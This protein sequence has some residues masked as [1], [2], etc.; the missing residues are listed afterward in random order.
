MKKTIILFTCLGFILLSSWLQAQECITAECHADFKK[1]KLLHGPVAN[2]C[3][4]CHIQ[5]GE[6]E[7]TFEDKERH[8]I[9][10]HD[11]QRGGA[12]VHGPLDSG[13][14]QDCHDPHGGSD[15]SFLKAERM[16]TMCFECHDREPMNKKVVHGPMA[17]GNCAICHNPHSSDYPMLL[18][19][20][21][22]TLC[23]KCH[24]DKDYSGDNMFMH[25]PLENGCDGCH[26][27]HASDFSYQLLTPTENIC[28]ACHE[29][30][31]DKAGK[32]GFKH[33]IVLQEKK[34]ANCHDPHG[35]L[36]DH[37]LT[38][39]QLSVCLGCH[40]KPIIGTDGKDY[41]I[42]TI[43]SNNPEKH[44]PVSDGNC[45]GC[46]NPH[47]SNS[48]KIL[49]EDFPEDF[50]TVF[51]EEKYN[52]CFQCHENTLVRD[53][54]TTTLTNFR[55]GSQN[56]HYLHVNREKGR[57]CR[58]C[59]EVHAGDQPK[60]I[61]KETP[62]GEWDIPLGFVKS[63]TGGSCSPGCHKPFSYDRGK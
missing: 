32:V 55:N 60:H 17:T 39:D 25:T 61:R 43:V 12:N 18:K 59:H 19:G 40:N 47:G 33:P 53:Q 2:D 37:N 58:A 4:A 41:N 20:S 42:Y 56:L 46:H 24:T 35:S 45:T 34:C 57:T 6:H 16:D 63:E 23:I 27:P 26:D 54:Q 50:Y 62:F 29:E 36:Y 22:E 8:C 31:I 14:C 52:L 21:K 7:F 38:T 9:K 15:L 13:K 44:G 49:I 1:I 30:L 3:T 48:Y 11:D 10:C 28:A 5:T 51:E